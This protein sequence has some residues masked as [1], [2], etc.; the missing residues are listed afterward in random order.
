M[1]LV[2]KVRGCD[3]NFLEIVPQIILSE[4]LYTMNLNL[5]R[6]IELH[7]AIV[8]YARARLPPH[9]Q[10]NI[11]RN[12][13]DAYHI[14]V[15]DMITALNVDP[16]SDLQ[17]FQRIDVIP[18]PH[19]E[20]DQHFWFTPFLIGICSLDDMRPDLWQGLDEMNEEFILLY[21]SPGVDPGGLV[22]SLST[23]QVCYIQNPYDDPRDCLW[24]DLHVVLELYL[25]CI[26]SGKFVFDVQGPGWR[27]EEF[28]ERELSTALEIWDNLVA[29]I[30]ARM[31]GNSNEGPADLESCGESL[32]PASVLS[33]YPAIPPFAREF[34]SRARKPPFTAIAPG[35]LVPDEN[36]I[37]R[38][39]AQLQGRHPE[40]VLTMP[41]H[42]IVHCPRFLL[43]P[44]RVPG[45]KFE[46]RADADR[47]QTIGNRS[48]ILDDRAGLYLEPDAVHAHACTLL[49]PFSLG[50]NGHVLRGDG[51][52]IERPGQCVLYEHGL[53]N[54]FLPAHG[55]PLAAIL[56]N[57]W[58]QIENEDW[59]VDE[60][61]VAGGEELWKKAD[62]EEGA[63]NFKPEGACF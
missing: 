22:L 6:S 60:H 32:I 58:E 5:D 48:R 53:C 34:L 17:Q 46:S 4:P 57:W 9:E 59:S 52:R 11:Q 7:N 19:P 56:V 36:F 55:T 23:G 37:H 50:G 28:T 10:A 30:V 35:L 3:H 39:G 41:Q 61:G 47:W 18:R 63:E 2:G 12:W 15:A 8:D 20:E 51:S 26:D 43:F 40:A 25:R 1:H 33:S 24:G 14:S 38:V 16:K 49:L 13:F 42:E 31:A 62:A 45:V 21:Q 44:W 54:P 27:V 29:A